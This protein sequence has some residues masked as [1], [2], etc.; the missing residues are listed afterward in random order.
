MPHLQQMQQK[1]NELSMRQLDHIGLAEAQLHIV[2]KQVL[3]LQK[4]WERYLLVTNQ[5]GQL[6]AYQGIR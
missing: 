5:E 1:M 3:C 2:W 6:V 4:Q